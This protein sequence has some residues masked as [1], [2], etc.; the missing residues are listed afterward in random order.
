[1]K[2]LYKIIIIIIIAVLVAIGIYLAW[3]KIA[4]PAPE[5]APAAPKTGTAAGGE[6]PVRGAVVKISENKVFDFWVAPA[7]GEVYYL[8]PDGQISLAKEGPDLEISKQ[9]INA[10]NAVEVAPGAGKILAAFGDPLSPQWGIFDVVDKAWR[11][12]PDFQ[13][14][15]WGATDEKLIAVVKNGSDLN[16]AEVDLTKTPPAY[17]IIIKDF[18]FQN[19]KLSY[20]PEN[21]LIIAEAPAANYESSVSQLDLKT[22]TLNLMLSPQRGEF[23]K[24]S[25]DK[26]FGFAWNVKDGFTILKSDFRETLPVPFNT[27]PSKCGS[28]ASKIYCF[29]PQSI[30]STANLP[31]D[32]FNKRFFSIDD[33]FAIDE[34]TGGTTKVLDGRGLDIDAKNPQILGNKLYF[35]NRYDNYL[36]ELTLD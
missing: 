17:K 6:G 15:T 36:Y 24:W 2:R 23:I 12:L 3:R 35:I 34:E 10:L 20:L 22:L 33:L 29:A 19:V 11:P 16:L 28:A 18:R 31:D 7:T 13:N 30:P 9:T 4:G 32:Y 27:L 21:R 8:L 25:A 1:M 5:E 26:N 14:A